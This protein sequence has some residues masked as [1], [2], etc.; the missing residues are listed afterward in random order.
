MFKT[1]VSGL[2]LEITITTITKK[3]AMTI[4]SKYWREVILDKTT[5]IDS[6]FR[7]EFLIT[8]SSPAMQ[9]RFL[10]KDGGIVDSEE[11]PT[12]MGCRETVLMEVLLLPPS[13]YRQPQRRRTINVDNWLLSRENLIHI[14]P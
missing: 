1:F 3:Y 9:R 7:A 4:G 13:I 8:L 12:W 11:N 2:M 5:T 6:G 14:Y 10:F